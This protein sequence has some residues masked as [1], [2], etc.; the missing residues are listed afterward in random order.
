MSVG[1]RQ[2]LFREDGTVVRI[3]NSVFS[4][5]N[6]GKARLK[7]FANTRVR[8]FSIIVE[9]KDRK[10]YRIIRSSG[11]Y[12]F[13]DR[14]GYLRDDKEQERMVLVLQAGNRSDGAGEKAEGSSDSER[15]ARERPKELEWEPTPAEIA[16]VETLLWPRGKP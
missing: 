9:L 8:R 15:K 1:F 16:A 3:P 11:C 7:E 6:R 2:F 13:F 14:R 4:A 12:V 5:V 10:P